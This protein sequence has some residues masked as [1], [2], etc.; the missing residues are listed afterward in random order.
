MVDIFLDVYQVYHHDNKNKIQAYAEIINQQRGEIVLENKKV[1]LT[2]VY[3]AKHFHDFV[4]GEIIKRVIVNGESGSSW[5]FIHFER[6]NVNVVSLSDAR[7]LM[8]S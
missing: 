6:L 5:Y 8:S 2:N 7:N 1:W 4:R 3:H